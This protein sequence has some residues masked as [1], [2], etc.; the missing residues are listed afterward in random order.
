MY[1][2]AVCGCILL[3]ITVLSFSLSLSRHLQLSAPQTQI[4]FKCIL[5]LIEFICFSASLLS[6]SSYLV[7]LEYKIFIKNNMQLYFL[8]LVS[9]FS[10]WG[11]PIVEIF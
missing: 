9:D 1:V 8:L 4:K 11:L 6:S 10:V 7:L 2:Y 5:F 3:C